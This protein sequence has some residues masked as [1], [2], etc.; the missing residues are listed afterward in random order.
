MNFILKSVRKIFFCKNFNPQAAGVDLHNEWKL[1]KYSYQASI[2]Y[3]SRTHA[4]LRL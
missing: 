3:L 1:V 4:I 2:G